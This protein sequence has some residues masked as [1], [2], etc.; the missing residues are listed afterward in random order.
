MGSGYRIP[1]APFLGG[2]LVSVKRL[3]LLLTDLF[4]LPPCL[5]AGTWPWQ[6]QPEQQ[7]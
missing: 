2:L 3:F 1:R 6:V 7:E 4:S 5:C